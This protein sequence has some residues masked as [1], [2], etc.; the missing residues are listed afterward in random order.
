MKTSSAMLQWSPPA[1]DDLGVRCV[2]LKTGGVAFFVSDRL[3][4][5]SLS[6][7]P[8]TWRIR[9]E[10]TLL[11]GSREIAARV[12]ADHGLRGLALL[13]IDPPAAGPAPVI[14]ADAAPEDPDAGTPGIALPPGTPLG[15]PG[16]VTGIV[17]RGRD[18][19]QTVA[20]AGALRALL[21]F[22]GPVGVRTAAPAGAEPVV[23]D[24]AV[25]AL[26]VRGLGGLVTPGLKSKLRELGLD[27]DRPLRPTYPRETWSQVLATAVAELFPGG[28]PEEGY[29]QLSE[30]CISGIC[31]M[32]IGLASVAMSRLLG[33][34]R[35]LL[36]LNEAWPSV[37]NFVVM[38]VDELAV[39]HFRVLLSDS[40]GHPAYMQG[41]IHGAV[42]MAGARDPR[43][44]VMEGALRALCLDVSWAS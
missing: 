31:R 10:V 25:E 19:H 8:S 35:S 20:P 22:H 2:L 14:L 29:R 15:T 27:L 18:G 11:D 4:A 42:K 44:F 6:C 26:F 24:S 7:V 12:V 17:T 37:N 5:T 9:P 32:P 34:R 30:K 36:R 38:K 1:E 16:A 23:F 28:P 33:P 21:A 13:E 43:V 3:A 41:V 40:Y 39:N